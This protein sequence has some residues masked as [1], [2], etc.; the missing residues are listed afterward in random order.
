M[1]AMD[2]QSLGRHLQ[3]ARIEAGLTQQQLC[4]KAGISYSTLAKIERG[5]IKSPSVFTIQRLAEVLNTSL[6]Q[7][8]GSFGPALPG[9][10]RS[11]S[12]IT[13][14][15]FD[16]NGCLV[17]FFHHAFTELANETGM[18]IE[19]IETTFWQYN[20]AV[21][22]GEM[23]LDE[24]NRILAEQLHQM[25]DWKSYYMRAV[26]PIAEMHELVVWAS[27]HYHV[28]LLSNIMPGFIP[29]MIKAN[30][31]PNVEYD[32]IIDSSEVK[33][34]KPESQI[35]QLAGERAG[36][37][38]NEILFIDDSRAN[39]MAASQLGWR[40]MWFDDFKPTESVS[41]ARSSLELAQ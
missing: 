17:Q 1:Y 2:E 36:V 33:M 38:A 35:F 9:K 7:L 29:E 25:I 12:G 19:K 20:D 11:K 22:R 32:V 28:G 6:D 5:A 10:Y 31:I 14:I 15:Y 4:Q 8:M 26:T 34:I 16:I 39:I 41:R 30:L 27:H 21:C 3:M 24:F 18:P 37:D 23:S 40:V 13:F